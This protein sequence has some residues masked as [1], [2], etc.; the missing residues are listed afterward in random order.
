M[1]PDKSISKPYLYSKG[2]RPVVYDDTNAAK[3]YLKKSE[4]W[5]IVRFD[6]SDKSNYIDWTHEREWR[7]PGNLDFQLNKVTV[8]VPNKSAY[9][10][11]VEKCRQVEDRDVMK[12]IKG[13]VMLGAVFY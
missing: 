11:F 7:L 4:W 12:S 5:R 9:R 3:S 10:R 6:L 8:L 13:V 2:G 1:D